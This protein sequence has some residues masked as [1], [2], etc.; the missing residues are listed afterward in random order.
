MTKTFTHKEITRR[1][2]G[3]MWA[4]SWVMNGERKREW[5]SVSFTQYL[6]SGAEFAFQ[7]DQ[8]V[9]TGINSSTRAMSRKLLEPQKTLKHMSLGFSVI[10]KK[11][12]QT[13]SNTSHYEEW[14][15]GWHMARR[16][17]WTRQ[18]NHN[19]WWWLFCYHRTWEML[20]NHSKSS[21]FYRRVHQPLYSRWVRKVSVWVWEKGS[22]LLYTSDAAD[23]ERLV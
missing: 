13:S 9:N 16:D 22:C 14:K 18:L 2:R 20:D 5:R 1:G 11:C 4:Y 7:N 23:E 12:L 8:Q 6:S 17:K 10:P 3:R 15:L 19:I 21:F